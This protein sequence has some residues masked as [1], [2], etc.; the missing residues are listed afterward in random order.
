MEDTIFKKSIV[1]EDKLISYGF[2]KNKDVYKYKKLINNDEFEIIITYKDNK[3]SGKIIDKELSEEYLS[4]RIESNQGEF[5]NK[6]RNEYINLLNDIKS[7]CCI[8][9]YYIYDQA[10]RISNYIKEKYNDIPEFL[11]DDDNNSVFRNQINKKWYGIIMYINKNKISNEDK[12]VEIINIKI[13]PEKIE[14][15]LQRKG[16]Y[17][18]YHMNKKYW[19]SI[20]LDDTID[21]KD[22]YKL[23]DES[24]SYT[25]ETNEW[26]IPTNPKYWD[27]I[28]CFN[29]T[30]V[31]EWKQPKNI[32][33]NDKVYIYVGSPYSCIMY[34]CEVIEK[35]IESYYK[36]I[37]YLM[38]IKLI[39]KYQTNEYPLDILKKYDLKAIRNTRRMPIKLVNKIKEDEL[40]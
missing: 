13:S 11:W 39:K 17:K 5:V 37:D 14:K 19:I 26:V 32:N 21:D 18:A 3:I 25:E 35:N 2:K 10:N 28:N 23:L 27:I 34:K 36:N 16:Y 29:N 22:I 1:K 20:V 4:Y 30:D 8:N 38:K 40:N 24:H 9:K 33:I 6:I 15:L 7:K 12:M 31:I